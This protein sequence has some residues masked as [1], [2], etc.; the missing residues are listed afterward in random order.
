MPKKHRLKLVFLGFVMVWLVILINLF[1]VQIL[2]NETYVERADKQFKTQ[3]TLHA[4]RGAIY[5]RGGQKLAHNEHYFDIYTELSHYKSLSDTNK[6]E[7]KAALVKHLGV[8]AA[9]LDAKL[10]LAK[11]TVLLKQNLPESAWDALRAT[12]L[13]GRLK[14]IGSFRKTLYARTR[15]RRTYGDLA[16]NVIGF[17]DTDNKGISGLEKRF[18][19]KL[20]GV[21]GFQIVQKDAHGKTYSRTDYDRTEPSDGKHIYLTIDRFHQGILENELAIAQEKYKAKTSSGVILDPYTGEILAMASLPSFNSNDPKSAA[22]ADL[23]G[24]NRVLLDAFEPG[25]TFK[26]FTAAAV[27][28]ERVTTPT[29]I[30]F[31]ENGKFRYGPKVFR[32]DNHEFG[33]LTFQEVIEKSSNIGVIKVA[34]ELGGEK[35]YRYVRDFGF[36]QKIGVEFDGETAGRLR[37]PSE[38]SKISLPSMSFGH[39]FSVNALQLARAYAAIANGGKL[40]QPYLIKKITDSK[41][42]VI[43]ENKP[44]VIRQVISKKTAA[45]LTSFLQAVVQ[46][47]TGTNVKDSNLRIAGKTGTAQVY[48]VEKR[49]YNSGKVVASFAGFF[50]ADKPK[51]V[52]VIVINEPR[53]KH[54]NYGGWT[55]AP[56]FQRVAQQLIG[57]ERLANRADYTYMSADTNSVFVPDVVGLSVSDAREILADIPIASELKGDGKYIINQSIDV[58]EYHKD[59]LKAIVLTADKKFSS[60]MPNLRGLTLRDAMRK[61]KRFRID[62]QVKGSGVVRTQSIRAGKIV[63][64]DATLVLTCRKK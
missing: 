51:Y 4:K 5:D 33:D 54:L 6:A 23:H 17:V 52:A 53:Y 21:N 45:T 58:G 20:K 1:R 25:S 48:D 34:L 8:S 9:S 57:S 40:L 18:Q 10:G 39:E 42:N 22:S 63:K 47:G 36:G 50:P 3:I 29:D 14:N 13:S 38:W 31:C 30:I 2:Q 35:F 19:D 7:V 28:E 55:A 26:I 49:T 12:P 44:S 11:H 37:K 64:Q 46:Q 61:L 62:V 32:D 60:L 41:D 27:L 15:F 43:E 16:H 59:S 24:A 56:T